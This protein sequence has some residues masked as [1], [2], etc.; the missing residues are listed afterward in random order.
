MP[1]CSK[2]YLGS[3]SFNKQSIGDEGGTTTTAISLNDEVEKDG[4]E[5]VFEAGLGYWL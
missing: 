2:T 1:G 3:P 5:R 4:L